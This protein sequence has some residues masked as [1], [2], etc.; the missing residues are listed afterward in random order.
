MAEKLAARKADPAKNPFVDPGACEA[1]AARASAGLDGRIAEE[2][3]K[4]AP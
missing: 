3:G 2:A 4:P 1:Y